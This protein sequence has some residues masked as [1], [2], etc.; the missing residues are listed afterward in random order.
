M[1]ETYRIMSANLPEELQNLELEELCEMYAKEDSVIKPWIDKKQAFDEKQKKIL[2]EE[3][4]E[5]KKSNDPQRTATYKW[6][7]FESLEPKTVEFKK[8]WKKRDEIYRTMYCKL[9]PMM[10]SVQK[11]Y[12]M[13]S[14]VQRVEVTEMIL[15]STLRCYSQKKNKNT[16]FSTYYMTNLKNGMMTQINSMKCN[17]RSVWMNMLEDE[18]QSNYALATQSTKGEN[19]TV[20][21]IKDV[22]DSTNLTT[23][24]KQYIHRVMAGVTKPEELA[25]SLEINKYV[26]RPEPKIKKKGLITI[27]ME[28]KPFDEVKAGLTLVKKLKKSIRAKFEAKG[29]ELFFA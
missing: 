15:I 21:F 1:Y 26:A 20:Q 6:I 8:A 29:R 27:P 10:L 9:Y 14:P 18:E 19:D 28:T 22:E 7:N 4:E 5:I 13:L 12:P 23:L 24:E 16:K 3:L 25:K 11:N 2:T 17:K